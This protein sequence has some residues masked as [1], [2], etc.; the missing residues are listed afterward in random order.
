MKNMGVWKSDLSKAMSR[1]VSHLS[2]YGLTYEK[3]PRYWGQLQ[4]GELV[5]VAEEIEL[6]MY[7]YAMP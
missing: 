2:T 4:K 5:A 3:G 1:K 7:L 6:E